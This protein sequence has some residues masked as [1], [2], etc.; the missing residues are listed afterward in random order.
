[1]VDYKSIMR[2]G[3]V[4]D[5]GGD[6]KRLD[7]ALRLLVETLRCDSVFFLGGAYAD[8]DGVL[9]A[10]GS[11]A[12]DDYS[13]QNFLDDIARFVVSGQSAS[14]NS[15]KTLAAEEV[16]GA[17]VIRVPERGSPEYLDEAIPNL[18]F[19]MIEGFI[20]VL[21]QFKGDLT[22]EHIVNASLIL[23]GGSKKPAVVQIGARA[24]VTPGSLS[25]T[26]GVALLVAEGK[27]VQF[28]VYDLDGAQIH[29][30]AVKVG[31]GSKLS[32]K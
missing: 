21:I 18:V 7:Q 5:S 9:R 12:A 26:G 11:D 30:E 28:E 31:G 13:D 8:I 19:E 32:V 2:V 20:A 27:A 14:A 6:I 29:Q 24:F 22:K 1:V 17:P 10:R 25:P 4:A 23:H 3:L 16:I 15:G